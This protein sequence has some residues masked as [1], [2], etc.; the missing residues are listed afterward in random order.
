MVGSDLTNL[1]KKISKYGL[2][3]IEDQKAKNEYVKL[4]YK[5]IKGGYVEDDIKKLGTSEGKLLKIFF[6]VYNSF[7]RLVSRYFKSEDRL[8][9]YTVFAACRTRIEFEILSGRVKRFHKYLMRLFKFSL[10]S[11]ELLYTFSILIKDLKTR[12]LELAEFWFNI[13]SLRTLGCDL[14]KLVIGDPSILN[15]FQKIS[16]L[17]VD[18]M[19]N[20][21]EE[22]I[23]FALF[24]F[25]WYLNK[26]LH[27][28]TEGG[29]TLKLG[30]EDVI[31]QIKFDNFDDKESIDIDL[32]DLIRDR[33]TRV[34]EKLE[35][36]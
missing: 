27:V 8:I 29:D 23:A 25:M 30:L 16:Q 26:G 1:M 22:V 24:L 14:K 35:G 5:F 2:R 32:N 3:Y 9:D 17:F 10:K 21:D 7:P 20:D 4:I 36:V 28:K 31:E 11:E 6:R 18:G 15:I 34:L 13:D 19:R 12:G 33:L